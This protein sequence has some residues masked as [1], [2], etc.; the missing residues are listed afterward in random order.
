MATLVHRPGI[1]FIAGPTASGKSEVA[2]LLAE[3]IGAEIVSVDSMQVYRGMD[4]GTA[5]PSAAD[6]QRVRHHLIDIADITEPFDAAQ[7]VENAQMAVA[8]IRGRGAT[9]IF[10]GG[11]GFYFKAF[12][13]GLGQAPPGD[14]ELRARLAMIPREELL[15]ELKRFDPALFDRIDQLNLRRVVRAIE[16]IRL[17]GKPFSEQRAPSGKGDESMKGNLFIGLSRPMEDL[18]QRINFRV[19]EMFRRGLVPETEQLL[20]L[21]LESNPVA[22][23]ALGYRQAVE[24]LRKRLDLNQTVELVK[25]RTRQF[26]KRQ[27]TWF[28]R[29]AALNWVEIQRSEAA[30]QTAGRLAAMMINSN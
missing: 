21:G 8:D 5:K 10:S 4:I 20:K 2:L 18:R 28:R 3:R 23:Q 19:D 22:M 9:P 30:D 12:L 7:F 13:E 29:Q 14:P 17:T 15:A 24:Y 6:R 11:T 1:I 16:V 27:V 26:A 25:L